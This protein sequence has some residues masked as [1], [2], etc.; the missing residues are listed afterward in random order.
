MKKIYLNIQSCL[1]IAMV[2]IGAQ[3]CRKTFDIMPK[4]AVD[5][6]EMYRN[7]FDADAAVIGIYG[8]LLNVAGQYTI[9]NELRG[10]LMD[11]TPN[12]DQYLI[13]L[14]NHNV[15][16]GN[17]YVNPRSFF[18]LILNCNDVLANFKS[19]LKDGRLTESDYALRYSDIAT[20]RSWLYL[21]LG[22]HFG[23]VPYVT[24]P[25]ENVNDIKNTALFPQIGFDALLDSLINFTEALPFK[26]EYPAGTSLLTTVDG[27]NLRK[28]YIHKN[29]LLGDLHLW[30]GN[31]QTAATRY[32]VVMEKGAEYDAGGGADFYSTYKMAYFTDEITGTN[33]QNIFVFPFNDR[34]A[35]YEN[36]WQLPFDKNFSPNNPFIDLFANTGAGKYLVKPSQNI[37]KLWNEQ[38]RGLTPTDFRGAGKSYIINNGVPVVSKQTANYDGS[39]PFETTGKWVLYRAASLHLRFAEAANRDGYSKLAYSFLNTGIGRVYD[40][41]PGI[42][43]RNVTDIMHTLDFPAPYNFDARNGDF[44]NFRAP[45][46]R[47]NGIRN[48]AGVSPSVIT[49]ADSAKY[50][51]MSNPDPYYREVTDRQGLALLMEDKL[52]T[53]GAL[54]L[55]FEGYRW[56][57]LLRIALRREKESPGSGGAFMKKIM[58]SK[59]A[60]SE[61][62]LAKDLSNPANWYLPFNWEE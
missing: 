14:N 30:K 4:D 51:D 57:D 41:T 46:Y 62:T 32:R 60:L 8:K 27:Y 11:V 35:G 38:M 43:G 17:P 54:E 29:L 55:A 16:E 56:P 52:V 9:L 21:Q 28:V 2:L 26:E 49:P 40:P 1:L 36:I 7:V 39:L 25:V 3:S 59:F 20:L 44:P 48:R 10:D 47:H 6:S 15:Q 31:Y 53:E 58:E 18:E 61:G 12:S 24:E 13:Q 42:N 5:E 37:I 34:T 33:W 23:T 45:W 50:F 22:T 19:M